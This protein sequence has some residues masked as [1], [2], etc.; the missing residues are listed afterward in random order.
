MGRHAGFIA[1]EA[2]NASRIVNICLIPEFKFNL[3]GEHGFLEFAY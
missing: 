2:V 1:M 3:Y